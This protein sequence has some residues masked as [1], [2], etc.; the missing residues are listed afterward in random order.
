MR[1]RFL[2]SIAIGFLF[3]WIAG[4]VSAQFYKVY[5]YGTRKQG[6]AE[7]V[8]WISYIASSDLFY[9]FFDKAVNREGLLAHSF[10]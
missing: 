3:L 10:E 7:L 4:S 5:G 8:Y 9:K 6:E 2:S 1:R